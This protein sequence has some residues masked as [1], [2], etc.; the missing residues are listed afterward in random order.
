MKLTVLQ[1]NLKQA[2]IKV[3]RAISNRPQ[4][5]ILANV[6]MEAKD[7]KL[8]LT[9]TDLEL[10]IRVE[11]G[12]KVEAEGK[13]T[14]PAKVLGEF[15]SSIPAGKIE[16]SLEKE[17]LKISSGRYKA[18]F[19]TIGADEYPQ[20]PVV[21]LKTGV[22]VKVVKDVLNNGLQKVVYAAAKDSMRPILTG[23]LFEFEKRNCRLVAT[24]GFRLSVHKIKIEGVDENKIEI[25]I[26]LR[27][28]SELGRM[29]GEKINLRV[30]S[31]TNQVVFW[32]EETV[33]VT[34][35]LEGNYPN[36]KKIIPKEFKTR[37][38]VEREDLLEGVQVSQVFA[39]ENSNVLRWVVGDNMV[40]LSAESP[41]MGRNE[42]EIEAEVDGE[43]GEIAFNGKFLLDFLQNAQS[44]KIEIG[45]G[46]S[47][48]PGSFQEFGNDKFMYIVMPINL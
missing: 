25:V 10:G 30:L 13:V 39:R 48:S 19:Q 46:D 47:L 28:V 2:L 21:D 12:A 44:E 14:V 20:F 1:E 43:G 4:L 35:L 6:L 3:N 34:Q 31:E 33:V 24:D 8:F 5:P 38:K 7:G 18:S 45:L 17:S 37:V 29:E 40:K 22:Q 41:E 42:V 27:G 36:Y 26:P 11:V 23:V 9:G 16:L 32:D 15:V